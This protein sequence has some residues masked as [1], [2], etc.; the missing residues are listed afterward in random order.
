M[1]LK[2]RIKEVIDSDG[3]SRYFVQHKFFGI[4]WDITYY[5]NIE[6]AKRD[7]NY[8]PEVKTIIHETD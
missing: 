4:W 7:I 8:N 6:R 3:R 5:N 1:K 2:M